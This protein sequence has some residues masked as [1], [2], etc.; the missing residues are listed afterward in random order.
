MRGFLLAA[1]AALVAADLPVHC[2]HR[3][4]LGKW[5]FR[6]G[7]ADGDNSATCGHGVPDR[8][9][10]MVHRNVSP[11]SPRFAVKRTLEVELLNPNV[12]VG[13]GGR[14]GT[15]TAIYDEGIEVDM[16]GWK[17]M[18]FF[19]YLPRFA[20]ADPNKVEHFRSICNETVAGWYHP[21]DAEAAATGAVQKRNWGCFV[22][23][24]TA[25]AIPLDSSEYSHDKV[26][27]RGKLESGELILSATLKDKRFAQADLTGASSAEEEGGA[28]S[29]VASAVAAAGATDATEDGL[30]AHNARASG[31]HRRTAAAAASGG[32]RSG[33]HA[34]RVVVEEEVE[35][36]VVDAADASATA[37]DGHVSFMELSALATVSSHE[38]IMGLESAEA[39]AEVVRKLNSVPGRLWEAGMPPDHF[40][41]MS[42]HEAR[43]RLGHSTTGKH[44]VPASTM[45]RIAR[46]HGHEA[47]RAVAAASGSSE[48]YD[49]PSYQ[50]LIEK[51]GGRYQAAA[52][53]SSSPDLSQYP[54]SLD[55]STIDHGAYL[56]PVLDQGQCGSCY[57]AASADAI[58]ARARIRAKGALNHL[59][60]SP[61]SVVQCSSYNQG[62]DGG[63]PFL[64]GKFGADI[65]FVPV[66]CMKYTASNAACPGAVECP[67]MAQLLPLWKSIQRGKTLPAG[68]TG[69]SFKQVHSHHAA[70]RHH[71]AAAEEG[72]NFVQLQE[73]AS[74][75][76]A[77]GADAVVAALRAASGVT[78]EQGAAADLLQPV[79]AGAVAVDEQEN[80]AVAASFAQIGET[81]SEEAAA[82]ESVG[83]LGFD[84]AFGEHAASGAADAAGVSADKTVA[85]ADA[86]VR[87]ARAAARAADAATAIASAHRRAAAA[88]NKRAHHHSAAEE[89]AAGGE[90]PQFRASGLSSTLEEVVAAHRA[91]R[92]EA[93][94]QQHHKK[95]QQQQRRHASEETVSGEAQLFSESTADA[96]AIDAD[97][98]TVNTYALA[99]RLPV[100]RYEYVGGYYG[101]CNEA[102]MVKELQDGPIVIAFNSPGDLFYYRG[103]IYHH[104]MKPEAEYDVTPI[105]RWEK[106]NHAVL[107]VGYGVEV[108][109]GKKVKYWK[110]K[111]SWS[112]RWG[113]HQNLADPHSPKGY[114]RM[115]RGEDVTAV[116]SMAVVL[117]P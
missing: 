50:Q 70:R 25:R 77:A 94:L 97:G 38:A 102:L 64:V 101:A 12:A 116:E 40:I 65:G 73:G 46:A 20:G 29:A 4:I 28:M 3:D 66:E 53:S 68:H 9:M 71:A 86:A 111:N 18:T 24:Q 78:A 47:A 108:I 37:D 79:P 21:M 22:A 2:V 74:A 11:S 13:P 54:E 57:A 114:F 100:S 75:T 51:A 31:H 35:A 5:E 58:T 33:K 52:S 89:E 6:L 83:P 41:G 67:Q 42:T 88:A 34:R 56:P 16:D 90:V 69:G 112:T 110:I 43:A 80:D 93:H 45:H 85:T 81:V 48:Q 32:L 8:V 61:Q 36:D 107:L 63:Y 19:R 113:E 59:V 84:F 106:T 15:W 27:K 96:M 10:T 23:R 1:A 99:D 117:D 14:R 17:Y 98:A 115:L 49:S 92:A 26:A 7:S 39:A 55:W 95:Q 109:N 72:D 44:R 30:L 76:A 104:A 103:G 91:D 82:S 60:V 105:S 87:A 62:C